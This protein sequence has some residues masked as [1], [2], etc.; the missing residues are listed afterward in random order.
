ME[1]EKA[2]EQFEYLY[3]LL[4]KAAK[5]S[6]SVSI[7]PLQA[8][9]LRVQSLA[10]AYFSK[11]AKFGYICDQLVRIGVTFEKA[12][13][14]GKLQ[15]FMRGRFTW[16]STHIILVPLVVKFSSIQQHCEYILKYIEPTV[17]DLAGMENYFVLCEYYAYV[18]RKVSR[19]SKV[20][21]ICATETHL[22]A[23]PSLGWKLP[24]VILCFQAHD[25]TASN[26][27][28]RSTKL[29]KLSLYVCCFGQ[30][31]SRIDPT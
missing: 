12:N 22:M 8:L 26:R 13:S 21:R 28:P 4:S 6:H 19:G 3:R 30:D 18:S 27:A 14:Q 7:P 2:Q 10:A 25:A 9:K 1:E 24:G 20:A 23:S 16:S 31:V 29:P 17:N 5:G 15:C 11:R